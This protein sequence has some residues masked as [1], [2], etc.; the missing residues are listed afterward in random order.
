MAILPQSLKKIN[1]PNLYLTNSCLKW[2]VL[3]YKVDYFNVIMRTTVLWFRNRLFMIETVLIQR[4]ISYDF[5]ILAEDQC[6]MAITYFINMPV[7][8][9]TLYIVY[10]TFIHVIWTLFYIVLLK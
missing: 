6:Q 1:V 10:L 8:P 7:I 3:D 2:V 5:F 4:C 9:N